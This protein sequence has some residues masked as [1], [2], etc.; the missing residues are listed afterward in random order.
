MK[1]QYQHQLQAKDREIENVKI[2]L[3]SIQKDKIKLEGMI[4][5]YRERQ[6]DLTKIKQNL[7]E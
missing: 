4:T 7:A 1:M 3:D 2:K 5:E 6:K